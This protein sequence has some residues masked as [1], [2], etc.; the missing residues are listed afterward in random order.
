MGGVDISCDDPNAE[1]KFDIFDMASVEYWLRGV[2]NF[3]F[4]DRAARGVPKRPVNLFC[5]CAGT[6]P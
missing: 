5:C 6:A 4:D 3:Y 1:S 2:R